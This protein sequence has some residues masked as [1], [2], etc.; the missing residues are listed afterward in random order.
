MIRSISLVQRI[1]LA[2]LLLLP[3]LIGFSAF[4]LNQA[5]VDSL[6]TAEQEALLAQT[7]TLIGAA[8]PETIPASITTP[9]IYSLTLP[10]AL[11]NPAL[12]HQTQ[13]IRTSS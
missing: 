5:Y 2:S 1:F 13:A 8:E 10:N 7:Y 3:T 12:K 6:I 11:L 9:A 4:I